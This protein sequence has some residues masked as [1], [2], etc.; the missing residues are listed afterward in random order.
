MRKTRL[1]LAAKRYS[2]GRPVRDEHGVVVDGDAGGGFQA[3]ADVGIGPLA[4]VVDEVVADGAGAAFEAVGP[5]AESEADAAVAVEDDVALDDDV[6]GPGRVALPEVDGV[7]G[8]AV[9]GADADEEVVADDPVGAFVDVDS[10]GVG[11]VGPAGREL[12][13]AVLHEAVGDALGIA[14][15]GG[16]LDELFVAVDEAAVVDAE[17]GDVVGGVAEDLDAV[18]EAPA[19]GEVG[20]GD[21][22]GGDPE[23]V[24]EG[25]GR[26]FVGAAQDDG[27]AIARQAADEGAVAGDGQGPGVEDVGAVGDE[28]RG[29]HVRGIDGVHGVLQGGGGSDA[30]D[31]S[32]GV[33]QRLPV[34]GGAGRPGGGQQAGSDADGPHAVHTDR[35]LHFRAG[36][37][38]GE[39][40]DAGPAPAGFLAGLDFPPVRRRM[41][42][43]RRDAM[44]LETLRTF[45]GGARFSTEDCWPSPPCC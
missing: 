42:P 28:D 3:D 24:F 18:V 2:I 33:G 32:G 6:L 23:D 15:G 7:F 30:I 36:C 10:A 27:V 40:A 4:R 37:K 11:L 34:A 20:D 14:V 45:L 8:V 12:E 31:G 25:G 1:E 26:A 35:M 43:E 16:A 5:A 9:G 13:Q 29:G 41:N 19:E 22:V 21:V 17:A 39:P 44:N 38:P